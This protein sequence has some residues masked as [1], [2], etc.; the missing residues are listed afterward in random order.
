MAVLV[1]WWD[2]GCGYVFSERP[3]L[4]Y[5]SSGSEVSCESAREEADQGIVRRADLR[6][7]GG[8]IR[9]TR[10]Q[11]G[12][13]RRGEADGHPG[14][15]VCEQWARGVLLYREIQATLWGEVE[16]WRFCRQCTWSAPGLS[17]PRSSQRRMTSSVSALLCPQPP[18]RYTG[19][20]RKHCLFM[21]YIYSGRDA[22]DDLTN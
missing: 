19:N 16:L 7:A 20:Y 13:E 12:P 9:F 11:R 4:F 3:M 5:R 22:C 8:R 6:S 21:V 2:R 17:R 10:L 15:T 18:F 1:G 14:N